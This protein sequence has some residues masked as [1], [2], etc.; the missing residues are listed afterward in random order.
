MS[1]LGGV[2]LGLRAS[3]GRRASTVA[4]SPMETRVDPTDHTY[5]V[6]IYLIND[7]GRPRGNT[8]ENGSFAINSGHISEITPKGCLSLLVTP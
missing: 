6:I 7:G 8:R 2:R 3:D 4:V 1:T 5:L